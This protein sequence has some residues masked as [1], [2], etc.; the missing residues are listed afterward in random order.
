MKNETEK[1]KNKFDESL[2][3]I[4]K[5]PNCT[6]TVLDNGTIN[7]GDVVRILEKMGETILGET[8]LKL[9]KNNPDFD[10]EILEVSINSPL[11]ESIYNKKVGDTVS[12]TVKGKTYNPTI[13]EKIELEKDKGVAKVKK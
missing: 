5:N 10:A 8:I 13:L 4:S 11:G 7:I 1:Q 2:E 9:V 12:Y 6:Y 3:E